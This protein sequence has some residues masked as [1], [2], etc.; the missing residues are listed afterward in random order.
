MEV[1]VLRISEKHQTADEMYERYTASVSTS[2]PHLKQK[3]RHVR[4][5]EGFLPIYLA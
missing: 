1:V 4:I 2:F 5:G 3:D